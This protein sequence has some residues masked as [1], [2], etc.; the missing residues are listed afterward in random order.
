VALSRAAAQQLGKFHRLPV[1]LTF[2]GTLSGARQV[3]FTLAPL[4]VR[5]PADSWFHINPPCSNCYTTPQ[6]V[7]IT[8]LPKGAHVTVLCIGAGCPFGRRSVTPT[9]GA[10]NLAQVVGSSHLEPGTKLEVEITATSGAREVI[11]YTM[12]RGAVP[13]RAIQ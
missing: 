8:G 11:V 1:E 10:L 13:V 3:V 5:T 4:R 12:Q 2:A 9:H 7:P 6:N